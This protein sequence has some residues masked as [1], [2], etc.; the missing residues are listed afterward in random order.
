MKS[1]F[2]AV[3]R[4]LLFLPQKI[5]FWRRYD[6]VPLFLQIWQMDPTRSSRLHSIPKSAQNLKNMPKTASKSRFQ[7][8]FH[9]IYIFFTKNDQKLIILLRFLNKQKFGNPE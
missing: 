7:A 2:C 9:E 5:C 1:P 3:L 6:P 8:V 4:L